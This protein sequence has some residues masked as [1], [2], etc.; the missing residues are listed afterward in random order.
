MWIQRVLCYFRCPNWDIS[1]D[2]ICTILDLVLVSHQC[3]STGSHRW[4]REDVDKNGVIMILDM[5]LVSNHFGENWY[6]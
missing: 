2:G 6:T 1:N 3:G 5:T 4:I